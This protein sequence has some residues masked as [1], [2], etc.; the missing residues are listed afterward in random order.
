LSFPQFEQSSEKALVPTRAFLLPR[1]PR[2]SRC[3]RRSTTPP[4]L[5]LE[6]LALS[7]DIWLEP[8]HPA[9]KTHPHPLQIPISP[10]LLRHSAFDS[11]TLSNG[12]QGQSVEHAMLVRKSAH[13][14]WTIW[15]RM[16][17]SR[18]SLCLHARSSVARGHLG[19]RPW[20][21]PGMNHHQHGV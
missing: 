19:R 4:R 6:H 8:E 14:L 9:L 7:L 11:R 5:E 15:F 17:S 16:T 3:G 10:W 13:R 18:Q 2:R 1:L 20:K 21:S 12:L